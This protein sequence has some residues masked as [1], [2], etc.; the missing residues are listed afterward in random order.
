MSSGV[1]R[2]GLVAK[3]AAIVKTVRIA[4]AHS[5]TIQ[6]QFYNQNVTR[7]YHANNGKAAARNIVQFVPYNNFAK[8]GLESHMSRLNLAR[9]VLAEVPEQFV[10][11]MKSRGIKPKQPKG[12]SMPVTMPHD[13]DFIAT[14]NI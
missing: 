8:A 13:T 1:R 11:F 12:G 4:N 7:R 2:R 10:S 9:E 6:V 5:E 14:T 3:M